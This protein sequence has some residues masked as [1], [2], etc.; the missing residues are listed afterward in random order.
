MKKFNRIFL[1]VLDSLGIGNEPDAE[2]FGDGVCSESTKINP[3]LNRV[4]SF[5]QGFHK[6]RN[7]RQV[8]E[9]CK[10]VRT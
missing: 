10:V 1:I 7:I 2:K 6:K 3:R 4:I 5:R 9:F 8:I